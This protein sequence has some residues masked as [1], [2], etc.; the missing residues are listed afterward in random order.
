MTRI[1][2]ISSAFSS[3]SISATLRAKSGSCISGLPP[4]IDSVEA[5]AFRRR[6]RSR[7]APT[8][9]WP[10]RSLPSRNLAQSQPRFSSPMSWSAGTFTSSKKTSLT[11]CPPSMVMI[12]RT[13]MPGDL[14]VGQQEGDALLLLRVRVGADQQEDPVGVLRQRGPGLLAVD[15]VVVALAHRA[16]LEAGEVGAGAG[17]GEAL[18]PPVV[19][20]GHARQEALLLLLRAEGDDDRAAHVGVEG[21]RLRRRRLLQLLAE[22]VALAER[23]ASGRPTPPAIPAPP[24]PW[25]SACAASPR[26]CPWSALLPATM[27]S[28]V[29]AGS[30]RAMKSRTS[31]RKAI[32]A[33]VKR[34]SMAFSSEVRRRVRPPWPAPSWRRSC[35]PRRRAARSAAPGARFGSSVA[36]A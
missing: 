13:V 7:L 28:R 36:S 12:G 33:S 31:L 3:T 4:S 14:H 21:E 25:R 2:V 6:M 1:T 34:S 29:S 32:S 20:V 27:R 16:R 5:M 24:S 35:R 17:L 9:A 22:D 18:A 30:S 23:P 10:K 11:S 19:E 8:R 26:P 15:D